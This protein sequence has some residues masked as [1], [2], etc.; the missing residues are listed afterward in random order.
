MKMN[1]LRQ[2]KSKRG[3]RKERQFFLMG[4]TAFIL[5]V[6]FFYIKPQIF[7]ESS[8]LVA[9]P[10]WRMFGEIQESVSSPLSFFIAKRDLIKENEDL[11]KKIGRMQPYSFDKDVLIIENRELREALGMRPSEDALLSR[12]LLRPPRAPYDIL[13]IDGGRERG[14]SVGDRVFFGESVLLG[15]IEQVYGKTARVLL[16]SS[17]GREVDVFIDDQEELL[18]A[19]GRGG[20]KFLLEVP[21]RTN[22]TE[23]D[24]L[25]RIDDRLSLLGEVV[26]VVLPE[27]GA[28][29]F[30]YAGV[31]VDIFSI[32]EVFV[33]P[34]GETGI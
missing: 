30:V 27:T 18:T 26:D 23:G 5:L 22:V 16:Y 20:G 33:L 15:E 2:H 12:V 29:K 14:F 34:A 1:Y 3:K 4:L 31:P 11:K 10:V 17:A 25:L 9:G 21:R 24:Y 7:S 19:K 6:S 28:L 13:I 8:H 32:R